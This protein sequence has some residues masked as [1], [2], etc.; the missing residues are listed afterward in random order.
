VQRLSVTT[1]ARTDIRHIL[2]TSEQQFG[3][4]ARRRYRRLI[5]QALAD[6]NGA[7]EPFGSTKIAELSADHRVYHIRFARPSIATTTVRR[8]RHALVYL[9]QA[10]RLMVLRVLHERQLISRHVNPER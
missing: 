6:L 8:P 4:E 1:A 2:A 7:A 9:I 5:Q 10:D 3:R